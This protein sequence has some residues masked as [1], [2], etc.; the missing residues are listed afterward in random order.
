MEFT[1]VHFFKNY[2]FNSRIGGVHSC[3]IACLSQYIMSLKDLGLVQTSTHTI[4]SQLWINGHSHVQ[5]L[6]VPCR[7]FS[8]HPLG[9]IDRI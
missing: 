5:A 8:C 4:P 9:L 7:S 1:L 6:L 2:P 3:T